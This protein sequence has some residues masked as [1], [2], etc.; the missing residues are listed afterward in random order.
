MPHAQTR[1]PWQRRSND[2]AVATLTKQLVRHDCWE[3]C[4]CG[5]EISVVAQCLSAFKVHHKCRRVLS[6]PCRQRCWFGWCK[7]ETVCSCMEGTRFVVCT[8]KH[9]KSAATPVASSTTA[10]CPRSCA[11]VCG[12]EC[13]GCA[14]SA[15]DA[16]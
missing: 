14:L 9:I 3:S 16:V 7:L 11:C 4:S 12:C 13:G 6:R 5:T 1:L 8:G 10:T 15:Q 2:V